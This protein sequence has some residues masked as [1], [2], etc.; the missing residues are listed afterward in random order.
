MQKDNSDKYLKIKIL[1]AKIM[2]IAVLIVSMQFSQ[3]GFGFKDEN[4]GYVGW[5]LAIAVTVAQFVF[6]SRVRNLNWTITGLGIMAYIYSIW[7]NLLG[8]YNYQDKTLTFETLLTFSAVLPLATSIFM[9]VFPETILSWAFNASGEGDLIGNLIAVGNDPDNIFSQRSNSG[10]SSQPRS[11]STQTSKPTSYPPT[12]PKASPAPMRQPMP[13]PQMASQKP[14]N[15]PFP[16][17]TSHP[18]PIKPKDFF[19]SLDEDDD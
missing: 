1:L 17:P 11:Q 4:I 9:D 2:G 13:H 6:N 7:T 3:S 10:N 18:Q 15:P 16:M 19:E 14:S 12:L 8:F 5:V